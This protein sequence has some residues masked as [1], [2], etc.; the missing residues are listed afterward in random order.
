MFRGN[1]GRT[2]VMPG[3]GPEQL[4]VERWRAALDGAGASVA[5]SAPVVAGE[6]IIVVQ[7]NGIVVAFERT[8]GRD[9]W[10]W[11]P[12]GS[13]RL[14]GAPALDEGRV[15]VGAQDGTF[16]ALDAAT[17]GELWRVALGAATGAP[18]VVAGTVYLGMGSDPAVSGGLVY[19]AGGCTCDA[20]VALDAQTGAE[21]WRFENGEALLYA[22]DAVTGAVRWQYDPNGASLAPP[23]V[24]DGTV[25]T[26]TSTGTALAIDARTGAERWSQNIAGANGGSDFEASPAVAGETVLYRRS[27]RHPDRSRRCRRLH[28]LAD[29]ACRL[30]DRLA[31]RCWTP[32]STSAIRTGP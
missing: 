14:T 25:F 9:L 13:L 2:G 30:R 16:V 17:G 3:P 18:A 29:H 32:R 8:S 1:A 27:Q 4:P 6:V 26:V 20:V 15:F 31:D 5:Q 12:G 24:A 23:S 10:R 19:L 21:R 7:P 22:F 28:P 11:Q